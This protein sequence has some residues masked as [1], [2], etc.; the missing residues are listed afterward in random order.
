MSKSAPPFLI[1]H[2][3][4][5]P[6]VPLAQSEELRD[7]L[8]KAG[9]EVELDVIKGAGHGFPRHPEINEKV[10]GF[11]DKHLKGNGA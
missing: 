10:Q 2:G 7:A 3:D 6:L 9:V 1:L 11:F 5:D 4:K 8:Q